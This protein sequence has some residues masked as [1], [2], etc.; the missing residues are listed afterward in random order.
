MH[1][2][3][4]VASLN[5]L[6]RERLSAHFFMRDMLY[7]EVGN[8]FGRPNIPD[9]PDL[10][11][12]AGKKLC[13]ELLEPLHA[14][15]GHV[16]IRSAYRSKAL[17]Q[18][19]NEKS[20]GCALDNCARHTWDCLDSDGLTGAT[21][22]IVIPWFVDYLQEH[23]DRS[24]TAMAWWIHD[25]LPYSE[26][27]FFPTNAAFNIRWYERPERKIKGFAKPKGLLTKGGWEN[28]SGDHTS[29]YPDFPTLKRRCRN[30]PEIRGKGPTCG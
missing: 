19:C 10:A 15:F 22:C 8:F 11:I 30:P 17:N 1:K 2:P 20:L 23:K 16:T 5:K 12:S 29:E 27:C 14:T 18:F 7:S 28:Q 6:G 24:W 13:N 21:A 4:S 9:N 25:H 26:M 3:G